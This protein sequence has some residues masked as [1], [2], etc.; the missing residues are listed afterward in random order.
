MI[1][2]TLTFV[3][4]VLLA[5]YGVPMARRAALKFGIGRTRLHSWPN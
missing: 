5:M 1:L 4:A 2:L 3:V